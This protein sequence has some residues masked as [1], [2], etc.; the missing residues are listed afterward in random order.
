MQEVCKLNFKIN[1]IPNVL[2]KCM[3]FNVYNKLFSYSFQYLGSS[4]DSLIK[5]LNKDHLKYL[6]QEFDSKVLDL[7]KQKRF[8]PYEYISHFE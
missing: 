4:L 7:V 1:V 5:N 8:Y 2:E 6:R 3:I